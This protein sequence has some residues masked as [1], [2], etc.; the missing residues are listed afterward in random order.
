[1]QGKKQKRIV[2]VKTKIGDDH[3]IKCELYSSTPKKE[4]V[5]FEKLLVRSFK[6]FTTNN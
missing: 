4:K 2:Y 1:M 5:S 6:K 3:K